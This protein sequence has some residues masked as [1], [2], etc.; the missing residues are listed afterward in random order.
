MKRKRNLE[1]QLKLSFVCEYE[2]ITA[3]EAEKITMINPAITTTKASHSTQ[4][5]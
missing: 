4:I 1:K 2:S 5:N 3:A